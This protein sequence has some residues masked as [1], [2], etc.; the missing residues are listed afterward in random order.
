MY[1][2]VILYCEKRSVDFILILKFNSI[3]ESWMI[4]SILL[5]F[6]LFVKSYQFVQIFCE[7]HI[8]Y[9]CHV[10]PR[11][12][13]GTVGCLEGGGF[14]GVV[15]SEMKGNG[16]ASRRSGRHDWAIF[17]SVWLWSRLASLCTLFVLRNHIQAGSSTYVLSHHL[18]IFQV[19]SFGYWKD[20]S[21]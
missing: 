14:G 13:G 2:I 9:I 1:I 4:K 18:H 19:V 20:I 16:L 5:Y 15:G 21:R 11:D 17:E 3:Q 12:G 8:V 7:K 6:I 10:F